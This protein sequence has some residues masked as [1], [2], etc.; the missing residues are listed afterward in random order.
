MSANNTNILVPPPHLAGL[1]VR[2]VTK[3]PLDDFEF[4][5]MTPVNVLIEHEQGDR[6]VKVGIVKMQLVDIARARSIGFAYCMDALSQDFAE[7]STHFDNNG[8][9]RPN[10]GCWKAEDF[11]AERCITYIDEVI[12]DEAWRG[13]GLG[14]WLIPKLFQLQNL[15][16]A[17]FIFTWPSV[18]SRLEHGPTDTPAKKAAHYAKSMRI[19]GFF[20][21]V[22]FRRLGNS[23]FF[24]LANDAS[25]PSRSIPV[26][27]DAHYVGA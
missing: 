7:L 17:Q 2:A 27:E 22:G 13:K 8:R 14:T 24:C 11:Q 10:K 25:H 5:A 4:S 12:I 1:R 3:R 16:G 15:R 19:I 21:K 9:L 6:Y 26:E 23:L 20:Q 18:L